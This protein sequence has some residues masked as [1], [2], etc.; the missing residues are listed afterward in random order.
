MSILS[1]KLAVS[2]RWLIFS[3]MASATEKLNLKIYLILI[4]LNLDRAMWQVSAVLDITAARGL[5]ESTFVLFLPQA[6]FAGWPLFSIS[7]SQGLYSLGKPISSYATFCF[8]LV[9]S[10]SFLL[11]I[12]ILLF[13]FLLL[14]SLSLLSFPLLLLILEIQ[15]RSLSCLPSIFYFLLCISSDLALKFLKIKIPFL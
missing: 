6:D 15:L 11:F 8:A 3:N 2:S 13:L 7:F 1:N 5:R 9:I 4:N 14:G 12:Y 10:K